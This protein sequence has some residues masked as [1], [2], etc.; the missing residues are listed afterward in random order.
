MIAALIDGLM[1]IA[2]LAMI[3]IYSSQIALVVLTAFVLYGIVRL[4]LY[5]V[6][7]ERSQAVIQ[8]KALENSSLIETTRAI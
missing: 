2:T 1:A 6:F 8:A 7:R 3:F 5:Q 4:V